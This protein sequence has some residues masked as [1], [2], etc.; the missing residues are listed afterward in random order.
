M[1]VFPGPAFHTG[2]RID[3]TASVLCFKRIMRPVSF[4]ALLNARAFAPA[5]DV[6]LAPRHEVLLD[7]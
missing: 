2:A 5:A 6:C 3:N 4:N 1:S 7:I